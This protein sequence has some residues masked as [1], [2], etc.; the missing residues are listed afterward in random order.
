MRSGTERCPS[1]RA[2]GRA[3]VKIL[4]TLS[5]PRVL[6]V[7]LWN[8]AYFLRPILG[9]KCWKWNFEFLSL[10]FF[11]GVQSQNWV[12]FGHFW[13]FLAC[14]SMSF[15]DEA[16][17]FSEMNLLDR[18]HHLAKSEFQNFELGRFG[19]GSKFWNFGSKIFFFHFFGLK[20]H[21]T[22]TSKKKKV[23]LDGQNGRQTIQLNKFWP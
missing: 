13:R 3:G 4:E 8:L 22:L 16:P 14:H 2:G 9:K 10:K 19:G 20:L 17:I 21:A 18:C 15:H 23:L 6:I 12:K 5:P 1:G 11:I 7:A